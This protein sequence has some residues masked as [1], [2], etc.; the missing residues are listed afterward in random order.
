MKESRKKWEKE[1]MEQE[2][3]FE[4][5]ELTDHL[6]ELERNIN[7]KVNRL[8]SLGLDV[9]LDTFNYGLRIRINKIVKYKE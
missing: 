3:D 7:T 5:R 8:K 6:T 4:V 2:K 9:I 1:R